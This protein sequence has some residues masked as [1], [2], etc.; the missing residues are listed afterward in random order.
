[1]IVE[2]TNINPNKAA[3]IGHLRNSVLGDSYV[4]CSKWLGDRGG[5]AELH[6]RH[7]R[8]GGGCSGGRSSGWSRRA[9][10]EIEE[11]IATSE[12]FDYVCWDVYSR[13][14][15]YYAD[16]PEAKEWRRE[17]L[18]RDRAGG[19]AIRRRLAA[20][21]ARGHRAPS[22]EDDC[23]ALDIQYDLLPKE[24]DIIHL[25]FVGSRVRATQAVGAR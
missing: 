1:M 18:H 13:M 5:D 12:R 20:L 3:H 24:S 14:S 23:R 17:T 22:P 4:R 7:R 9:W 25:H 8:A 19:G 15:Q 11:L 16:H 2:H 10:R 21:I 6:R